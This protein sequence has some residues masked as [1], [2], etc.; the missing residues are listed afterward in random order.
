MNLSDIFT[1]NSM[2]LQDSVKALRQVRERLKDNTLTDDQRT[3]LT[4]IMGYIL[5]IATDL[6]KVLDATTEPSPY[7][8]AKLPE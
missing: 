2:R 3:E 4:K 8:D 5:M 6:K 1:R 7:E